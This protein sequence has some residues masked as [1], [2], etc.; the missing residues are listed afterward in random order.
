MGYYSSPRLRLQG[1]AENKQARRRHIEW[2]VRNRPEGDVWL[3]RVSSIDPAGDALADAGGYE[4]I[5]TLWLAQVQDHSDQAKPIGHA[6][7]FLLVPDRS[8]AKELLMRA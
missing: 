2:S 5:R 3:S 4:G 7:Y 1:V 8:K 6:G